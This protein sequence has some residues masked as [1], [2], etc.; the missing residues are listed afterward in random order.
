MCAS[1]SSSTDHPDDRTVPGAG[2]EN[3]AAVAEDIRLD[4]VVVADAVDESEVDSIPVAVVPRAVDNIP[5]AASCLPVA[6]LVIWVA[7][8]EAVLATRMVLVQ[9]C[10]LPGLDRKFPTRT[11]DDPW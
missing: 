6:V 4:K 2:L 5:R 1:I 7:L 3:E 11:V 9:T 8:V 10:F